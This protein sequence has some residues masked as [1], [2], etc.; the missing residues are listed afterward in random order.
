MEN[1]VVIPWTAR[2]LTSAGSTPSESKVGASSSGL[3]PSSSSVSAR[4]DCSAVVVIGVYCL[5][6][7]GG[8]P[9]AG[10]RYSWDSRIQAGPPRAGHRVHGCGPD[11]QNEGDPGGWGRWPP[12]TQ[13]ITLKQP[14]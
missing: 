6:S 8:R 5:S 14:R 12:Q 4:P 11:K 1:A 10:H 3:S 2:A 7:V 13:R 9:G